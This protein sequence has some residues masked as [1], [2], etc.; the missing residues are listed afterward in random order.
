LSDLNIPSPVATNIY[1]IIQEALTNVLK[2]AKASRVSIILNCHSGQIIAIVEDDGC[3]FD[4]EK[5]NQGRG[6]PRL[7]L[8]GM[9]ERAELMG[10]TFTVESESGK[11]TT[12]YI[13]VPL[14]RSEKV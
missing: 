9:K 12:V 14:S 10:G 2:H 3:G 5:P 13:R 1:R 8:L 7:G 11:G 4:L 6:K